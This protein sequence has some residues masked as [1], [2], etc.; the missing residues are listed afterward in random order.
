MKANF[1][2]L[3]RWLYLG[4]PLPLGAIENRRSLVALDNLV[5]LI[6]RCLEHPG[7]ANQTLLVSDGEDLSTTALLQRTAAAMGKSA[8]LVPVPALV[9]KTAASLLG[10]PEMAERLCDSLQVETGKTRELLNWS[11]PMSVDEALSQTVRHFL[12]HQRV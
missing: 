3:M 5:D 9:V 1:L 12:T 11:P 4:I 8:R 7:A 6:V 10:K 2:N